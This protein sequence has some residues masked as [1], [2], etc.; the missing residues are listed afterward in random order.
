M[1]KFKP[2]E[3]WIFS[4]DYKKGE[5]WSE[6]RETKH[7]NFIHLTDY[8]AAQAKIKELEDKKE[9]LVSGYETMLTEMKARIE[10]LEGSVATIPYDEMNQNMLRLYKEAVPRLNDVIDKQKAHIEKLKHSNLVMREGL[11]LAVAR[12]CIQCNA[13]IIAQEAL[14]HADKIMEE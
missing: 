8:Q 13:D 1:S 14:A 9:Y 2:R 11:E 5:Y 6:I 4:G 7:G 10:E 3:F 12:A